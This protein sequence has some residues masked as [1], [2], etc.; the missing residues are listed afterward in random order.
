[1][2]SNRRSLLDCCTGGTSKRVHVNRFDLRNKKK[3]QHAHTHTRAHTHTHT[4]TKVKGNVKYLFAGTVDSL[5][6]KG[7]EREREGW[8]HGWMDRIGWRGEK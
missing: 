3:K 5:P 2:F 4:H 7:R 6:K 1:M 8:I